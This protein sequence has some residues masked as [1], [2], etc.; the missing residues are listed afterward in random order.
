MKLTMTLAA[1]VLWAGA[2]RAQGPACP[3][4]QIAYP[5]CKTATCSWPPSA[6]DVNMDWFCAT[7]PQAVVAC[8]GIDW[9]AKPPPPTQLD[10]IETMLNG[11][12]KY[13]LQCTPTSVPK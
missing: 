12:C 3:V 13:S 10:R 11:L 4:G 6:D 1:L 7:L 8:T 2:A 9:S 5:I